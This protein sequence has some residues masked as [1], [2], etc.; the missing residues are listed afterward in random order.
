MTFQNSL[1]LLG[2]TVMWSML[3][4]DDWHLQAIF[5]AGTVALHALTWGEE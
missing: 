4:I 3:F 5:A 1:L 2:A